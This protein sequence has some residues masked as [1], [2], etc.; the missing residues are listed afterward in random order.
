MR[1]YKKQII[2]DKISGTNLGSGVAFRKQDNTEK[3][4]NFYREMLK[5]SMTIQKNKE[6][7]FNFIQQE[8]Q[9]KSSVK[10]YGQKIG[11]L[12]QEVEQLQ[13]HQD[14]CKEQSTKFIQHQNIKLVELA[15][16][17]DEM[18]Q[19]VQDFTKDKK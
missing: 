1:K 4:D 9:S 5:F 7:R 10:E 12:M 8:K 14:K 17:C 15:K 2:P 19:F 16:T 11:K 13:F 3:M 18:I 6:D